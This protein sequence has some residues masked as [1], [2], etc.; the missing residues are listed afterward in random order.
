MA[1]N[2][3]AQIV[4]ANEPLLLMERCDELLQSALADA[5]CERQV[6]EVESK[7]NWHDI[8]AEHAGMSLFASAKLLDLRFSKAPDSTAKKALLQLC[9]EANADSRV[10]CRFLI[11]ASNPAGKWL[12]PLR[13]VAQVE[14]IKQPEGAQFAAWL[15]QRIRH[16]QLRLDEAAT[17]RLIELTEGNLLAANQSLQKLKLLY[18]E[19][20]ISSQQLAAVVTDLA[21][22]KIFTCIDA[23]RSGDWRRA[24]RAM[25]TVQADEPNPLPLVN[26]LW[27]EVEACIVL[28]DRMQHGQPTQA[29]WQH[30]NRIWQSRQRQLEK[31][32]KRWSPRVWQHLLQRLA[33]I[34]KMVKGQ[35]DGEPWLEMEM[36]LRVFSGQNIWKSLK[37]AAK[38]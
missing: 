4:V 10:L 24:L 13:E 32:A 35:A 26:L 9:A 38:S 25:Q 17:E 21:R 29:V 1:T 8:L 31:A 2:P 6:I 37:E 12:E 23:A 19:Q 20:S 16:H 7:T 27:S 15:K 33:D 5:A 36:C 11:D 30:F 22:Y 3:F 18:P 34:D 14:V 28:A